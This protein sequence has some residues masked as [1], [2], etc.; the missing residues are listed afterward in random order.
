M[1]AP[2]MPYGMVASQDDSYVAPQG[3]MS[4]PEMA[5]TASATLRSIMRV[6]PMAAGI[7]GMFVPGLTL[8]QPWIVMLAPY[9]EQSLDA[10]SKGNNGDVVL[11]LSQLIQHVSVNGLNSPFLTPTSSNPMDP[12]TNTY[13]PTAGPSQDASAQGSG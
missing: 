6:E 12:R 3:M 2:F 8:V 13:S 10:L 5:G 7:A 9:L 1:T 11:S 4:M